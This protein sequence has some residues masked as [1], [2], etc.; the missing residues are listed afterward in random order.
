[1]DQVAHFTN[2]RRQTTLSSLPHLYLLTD[3]WTAP[4]CLLDTDSKLLVHSFTP[5]PKHYL[6]G[7]TSTPFYLPRQLSPP[8]TTNTY[9]QKHF[10][11]CTTS[12]FH[13]ATAN[14]YLSYYCLQ[15]HSELLLLQHPTLKRDSN[16]IIIYTQCGEQTDTTILTLT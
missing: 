13:P 11:K 9:I 8:A 16:M 7:T 5:I 10:I 12:Y 2:M 15:P 4:P 1:M 3:F 6:V 14:P